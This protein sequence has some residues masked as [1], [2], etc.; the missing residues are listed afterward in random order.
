[1]SADI[2]RE[3]QQQRR[4][5][6]RIRAQKR[7][8]EHLESSNAVFVDLAPIPQDSERNPVQADR[9]VASSSNLTKWRIIGVLCFGVPLLYLGSLLLNMPHNQIL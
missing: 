3:Q 1:M 6:S 7:E 8:N 2:W 4:S 5:S 9:V